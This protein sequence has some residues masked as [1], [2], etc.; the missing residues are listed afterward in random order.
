MTSLDLP[1]AEQTLQ[2]SGF[3]WGIV[4][5]DI[6]DPN[7]D[8]IVLDQSPHGGVQQPPNKKITLTRITKQIAA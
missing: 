1:S 2:S 6:S 3:R 5:R 8:G 7:Q 4:Y